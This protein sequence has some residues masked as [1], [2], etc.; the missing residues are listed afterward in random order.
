M[1]I[2]CLHPLIIFGAQ[3]P[4]GISTGSFRDTR[5]TYAKRPRSVYL[6][7]F[8]PFTEKVS[9]TPKLRPVLEVYRPCGFRTKVSI[10]VHRLIRV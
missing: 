1:Q 10:S 6:S 3:A 9:V 7:L 2:G 5:Y 4:I 8:D